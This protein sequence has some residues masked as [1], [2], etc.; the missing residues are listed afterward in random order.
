MKYGNDEIKCDE[1]IALDLLEASQH[2]RT[3][4]QHDCRYISYGYG[5][6]AIYIAV[7]IVTSLLCLSN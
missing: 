3:S 1:L 2:C 4:D 6:L 5:L 7:A